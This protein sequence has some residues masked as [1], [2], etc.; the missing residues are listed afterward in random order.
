MIQG[1]PLPLYLPPAPGEILSNVAMN[2]GWCG[3]M[4]WALTEN[5]ELSEL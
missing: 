1:P 3:V 5:L 2:A 4:D